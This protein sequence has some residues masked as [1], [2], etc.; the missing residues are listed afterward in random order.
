MS[1]VFNKYKGTIIGIIFILAGMLFYF[2]MQ[3]FNIWKNPPDAGPGGFCEYFDPNLLVGEPMNSWSCFYFIGAGMVIIMYYDLIR[4]GKIKENNKYVLQKENSHYLITYGI[5]LIWVGIASFYM[6][7]SYR[8]T[9]WFSAGFLDGLSMNMY[10][11]GIIIMSLAI[12]FDIKK[13]NFYI[14]F[15]I[16][17]I[18]IVI[19]MN[20]N[21]HLPSLGGG[22]LFELLLIFAFL[23]EVLIALGL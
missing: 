17:I 19:L 21:L 18:I 5:L 7:G 13:R 14:I 1:E 8:S 6:H 12:V 22:G 4:M 10:M 23:N 11:S 15:L 16:D 20:L 2:I 3:I 9:P